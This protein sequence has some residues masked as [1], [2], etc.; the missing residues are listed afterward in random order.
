MR[1]II[2]LLGFIDSGKNTVGNIL[3]EQQGFYTESFAKPVKDCVAILFSWPRKL[4]E[5]DTKES[6]EFREKI[7]PYWSSKLGYNVT[8]RLMLQKF[9]TECMRDVID[10]NIW[11]LQL[12]NRLE[13]KPYIIT[14]V[15]FPNEIKFIQ[16]LGGYTIW[17]KRDPLPEWF[18][19]ALKENTS[20]VE[21]I[22]RMCHNYGIHESEWAWI[23][24]NVDYVLENNGTLE[25][26]EIKINGLLEEI[27][28]RDILDR[29]DNG[30]KI[31]DI[32][33]KS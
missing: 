6:R 20:D 30:E 29:L 4:L 3:K 26:L 11:L 32:G 15:R 1:L 19:C 5:G 25:D 16:S 24:S 28:V 10:P 8:P 12:E 21:E 17:V 13:D 31:E 7:D 2:G 33:T 27:Y 22:D 14:D 9:G 18:D 23:G